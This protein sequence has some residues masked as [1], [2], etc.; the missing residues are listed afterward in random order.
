MKL[1][2]DNSKYVVK[3]GSITIN[4]VSLTVADESMDT[5]TV[6]VIPHTFQNTT[7]K[8][9]KNGDK[10]NIETDIISKYV[11]KFLSTRDNRTGIDMEFLIKNGF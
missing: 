5:I 10:V 7:F 6:A 8:Y 3:K 4:G 1:D 2:K 11:E 9:L